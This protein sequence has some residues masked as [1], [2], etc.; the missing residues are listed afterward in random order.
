MEAK[1]DLLT[2]KVMKMKKAGLSQEEVNEG[3]RQLITDDKDVPGDSKLELYNS[4]VQE[5][6]DLMGLTS[7]PS[8]AMDTAC[9]ETLRARS[10]RLMKEAMI[11]LQSTKSGVDTRRCVKNTTQSRKGAYLCT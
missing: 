6:E 2:I 8:S 5:L 3:L 4:V 11:G 7:H 1:R 9:H 10:Q